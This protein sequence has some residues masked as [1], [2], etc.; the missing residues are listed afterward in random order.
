VI[1][2][3]ALATHRAQTLGHQ[4][5]DIDSFISWMLA[6]G[7]I[8]GHVLDSIFYHPVQLILAPWS[9]LYV[10]AGLSSFGGFVGATAGALLWKYF[11][12]VPWLSLGRW[13]SVPRPVRRRCARPILAYC[14][15]IMAV[16]PVAWALGRLGCTV[17]HDHPGLRTS[18]DNLLAVAYGPGPVQ[19]FGLIELR[20]GD[21]PRYDL[22]LL[23][24]LFTLIVAAV[25][26]STWRKRLPVGVYVATLPLVY[27]PLRFGLD[28]LRLQDAEGGDLRYFGLTPAQW[29]CMA[30]FCVGCVFSQR[31][32]SA[33]HERTARSART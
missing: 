6:G 19:H 10:W 2:G 23:E 26:A 29:G 18:S 13:F 4:R 30:L 11:E 22:G 5:R 33:R 32:F 15:I 21:A 25:C 8:G 20:F 16:F 3:S 24:F 28:Y 9:L 31:L 1:V 14:D 7:F 12:G 27:A 17:V